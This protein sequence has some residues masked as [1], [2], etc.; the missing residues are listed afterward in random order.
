[1]TF[2]YTAWVLGRASKIREITVIGHGDESHGCM[3]PV[4]QT[5]DGE[6]IRIENVHSSKERAL[7]V[8]MERL[9]EARARNLR[10][11]E[12]LEKRAALIDKQIK[13]KENRNEQ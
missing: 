8:A 13:A 2:P 7:S 6:Y 12:Q 4:A 11:A 1:M 3:Y 5:D 10:E 9:V